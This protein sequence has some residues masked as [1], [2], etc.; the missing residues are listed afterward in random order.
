MRRCRK[1]SRYEFDGLATVQ[2]C[3]VLRPT[4]AFKDVGVCVREQ[5][6]PETNFDLVKIVEVQHPGRQVNL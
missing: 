6:E 4:S 1:P 2:R 3:T 5:R